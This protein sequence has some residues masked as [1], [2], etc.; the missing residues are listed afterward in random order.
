VNARL[1]VTAAAASVTFRFRAS[2]SVRAYAA[3]SAAA[4]FAIV[5]SAFSPVPGTGCA[6][7]ICVPGAIATTSAASA[8]MKPADAA[9]A[10]D[11]P[12]N[13][14]MG[15]RAAIM[16]DTMARVESSSPPGVRSTSTRTV[17]PEVSARAIASSTNSAA[18]G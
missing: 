11:G 3:A 2:A 15:V 5:S 1:S 17:A 12:T 4:F 6:A 16:R 14:T 9:R 13:T 8:M 7:P 18:T 10:P